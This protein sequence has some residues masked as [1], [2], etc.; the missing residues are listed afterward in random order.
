MRACLFIAIVGLWITALAA[1]IG[2]GSGH[3]GSGA[4]S[5]GNVQSIREKIWLS[6]ACTDSH[7][8]V[9]DS[10]DISVTVECSSA[11]D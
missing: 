6:R 11:G 3:A 10:D 8:Y 7:W 1:S 4:A 5:Q 9:V 2:G